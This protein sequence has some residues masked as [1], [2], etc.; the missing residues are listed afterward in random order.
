MITSAKER[1][2]GTDD[3]VLTPKLR[4][5]MSEELA[6]FFTAEEVRQR[7]TFNFDEPDDT[8]AQS[9]DILT[10]PSNP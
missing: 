1:I 2:F 9:K 7:L 10:V 8:A 4:D 5:I 3:L 6:F